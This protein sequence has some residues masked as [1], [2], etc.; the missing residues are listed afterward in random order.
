[1]QEVRENGL[2]ERGWRSGVGNCQ[3]RPAS[4]IL[5]HN[6][7]HLIWK[8]TIIIIFPN[9]PGFRFLIVSYL[10]VFTVPLHSMSVHFVM[11]ILFQPISNPHD[12]VKH[13]SG[14]MSF[15]ER[16]YLLKNYYC[17]VRQRKCFPVQTCVH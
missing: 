7:L 4:Q 12:F 3:K 8:P 6:H 1:M 14:K 15:D 16:N 10:R 11:C 2:E 17:M 13:I 5:A 9:F